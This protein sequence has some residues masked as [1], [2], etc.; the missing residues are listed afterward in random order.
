[1]GALTNLSWIIMG[2]LAD[3]RV[4]RS[5][6]IRPNGTEREDVIGKH[7]TAMRQKKGESPSHSAD[8]TNLAELSACTNF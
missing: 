2:S 6:T 4:P 5:S 3:L 1:M 7:S 8:S